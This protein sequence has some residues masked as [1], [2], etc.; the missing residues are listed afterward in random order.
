[1]KDR[2]RGGRR[3]FWLHREERRVGEGFGHREGALCRGLD[4]G[5]LGLRLQGIAN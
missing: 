5:F 1:M 4:Q 3:R 2:G